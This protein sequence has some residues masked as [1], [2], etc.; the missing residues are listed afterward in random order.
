M[1]PS[2]LLV[3]EVLKRQGLSHFYAQLREYEIKMERHTGNK[4]SLRKAL[5]SM[6]K[7]LK[8]KAERV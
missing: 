1:R 6:K 4:A 3:Q 5:K 2:D 7:Q 8:Q